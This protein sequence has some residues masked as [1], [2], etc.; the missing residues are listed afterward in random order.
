LRA[1]RRD[2]GSPEEFLAG[3]QAE[4]HASFAR[5]PVDKRP[6][7]LINKTNQFNL[8][9]ERVTEGAWRRSLQRPKGFLLSVS[10]TDKFGP[11]GKIAVVSGR[12]EA[13]EV[14]VERWVLSC[15][16]F[17]RRVEYATLDLLFDRFAAGRLR[18]A[19]APTGR[20][21]PVSDFLASLGIDASGG[22]V[23]ITRSEFG[24]RCLPLH[25]KVLLDD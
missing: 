22:P 17:S 1:A 2:A 4:I 15:R 11:L 5:E 23:I 20:N 25:H 3:L 12:L 9:G 18:L 13:E 7:E 8:N 19:F 21:G 24:A 16:A 10:Y 14:V 6:L